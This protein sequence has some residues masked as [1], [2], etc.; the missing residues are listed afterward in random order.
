[1]PGMSRGALADLLI[2]HT[3]ADEKEARDRDAILAFLRQGEGRDPFD[4]NRYD[5][6][7]L[8]GSAFVLDAGGERLLLVHHARLDYER[9]KG[10]PFG[11]GPDKSYADDGQ[12]AATGQAGQS[13]FRAW[14]TRRPC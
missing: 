13:G 1:M 11:P 3:P 6:G 12:S 8:T 4:R 14:Q 5:P 7:H 10:T 9:E 2:A